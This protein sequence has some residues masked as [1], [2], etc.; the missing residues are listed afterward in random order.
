MGIG[1]I[2]GTGGVSATGGVVG[3]G[4]V[5][6]TGGVSGTGGASA[7]M[8]LATMYDSALPSAQSCPLNSLVNPCTY[9]Y[10]TTLSCAGACNT[11]VADTSTV[12]VLVAKWN[13]AGCASLLP[14]CPACTSPA[15]GAC[16]VGGVT[17]QAQPDIVL[18][19]SGR[20]VDVG[21]ATTQ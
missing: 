12:Q 5:A 4:G 20:C 18:P 7:C 17:T 11:Y 2:K 8:S 1:G 6:A 10:P 16:Q 14:K 21:S 9:A 15:S 3:T 19:Q 13:D